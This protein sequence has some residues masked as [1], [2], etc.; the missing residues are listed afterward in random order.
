MWLGMGGA[1]ALVDVRRTRE[2]SDLAIL[3]RDFVYTDFQ[4]LRARAAGADAVLL[5][6]AVLDDAVFFATVPEDAVFFAA[7]PEDAVFFAEVLEEE[8]FDPAAFEAVFFAA[9]PPFAASISDFCVTPV[10]FAISFSAA[11]VRSFSPRSALLMSS[12]EIPLIFLASCSCVKP[13]FVRASLISVP[14]LS[15]IFIPPFLCFRSCRKNAPLL[16]GPGIRPPQLS[17]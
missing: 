4:I 17:P 8:A 5:I 7:V 16:C 15:A 6:A 3:F 10:A 13:A 1:R 11:C 14:T 2:A 12:A 9:E